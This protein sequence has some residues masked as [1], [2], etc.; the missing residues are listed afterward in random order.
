MRGASSTTRASSLGAPGGLAV[1]P[2]LDGCAEIR[3]WMPDLK[4][5]VRL[6]AQTSDVLVAVLGYT[7]SGET[8]YRCGASLAT[9]LPGCGR[10]WK[11]PSA[12]SGMSD[13]FQVGTPSLR[14]YTSRMTGQSPA[15]PSP[16]TSLH[17]RMR[18]AHHGPSVISVDRND[19]HG[20]G[21]W[22]RGH[23]KRTT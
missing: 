11:V 20:T 13:E 10:G 23:A 1:V 14:A 3:I 22:E 4:P 12:R 19:K 18:E 5:V 9:A 6:E 15:N 8:A 7:I 2:H 16:S 17:M 21:D